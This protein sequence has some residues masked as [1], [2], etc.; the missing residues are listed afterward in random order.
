MAAHLF[1]WRIR[2]IQNN[3]QWKLKILM[4]LDHNVKPCVCV[5]PSLC[6]FHMEIISYP[7]RLNP[8]GVIPD[9]YTPSYTTDTVGFIYGLGKTVCS[10]INLNVQKMKRRHLVIVKLNCTQFMSIWLGFFVDCDQKK[11]KHRTNC[12]IES[13]N[14]NLFLFIF[15]LL[16]LCG[17]VEHS[18]LAVLTP[19]LLIKLRNSINPKLS[20]W[21]KGKDIFMQSI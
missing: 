2:S 7:T 13:V 3:C 15:L 14:S 11:A 18:D 4:H 16:L 17:A 21:S 8:D 20:T 1:L 12:F 6:L 9:H 19:A 5:K 10:I